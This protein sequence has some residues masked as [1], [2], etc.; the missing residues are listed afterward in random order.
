MFKSEM[1]TATQPRLS[2]TVG[3]APA[4]KDDG[5]GSIPGR[6]IPK[7]SKW[8]LWLPV[9]RKRVGAGKR[10]TRGAAIDSL[11]TSLVALAQADGNDIADH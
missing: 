8:Y 7:I 1:S 2:D 9:R 11:S 10:L 5:W 6:V 4:T 3:C